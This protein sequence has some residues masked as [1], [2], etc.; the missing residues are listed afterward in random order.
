MKRKGERYKL[1]WKERVAGRVVIEVT[2]RMEC[3]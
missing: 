2:P 3:G 1:I